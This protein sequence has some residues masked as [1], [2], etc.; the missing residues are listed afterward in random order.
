MFRILQVIGFVFVTD[1]VLLGFGIIVL[2]I[3]RKMKNAGMSAW[4]K[5][6]IPAQSLLG[7]QPETDT[8]VSKRVGYLLLFEA[9]GFLFFGWLSLIAIPV[10]PVGFLLAVF[11]PAFN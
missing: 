11:L 1:V 6:V 5:G 8:Q 7:G 4:N 2:Y 10:F 3:G 9:M